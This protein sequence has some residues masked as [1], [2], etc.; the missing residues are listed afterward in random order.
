MEQKTIN[1]DV[2]KELFAFTHMTPPPRCS[3]PREIFSAHD[4][5][6]EEE[7]VSECQA[8]PAVWDAAKETL[9]YPIQTTKIWVGDSTFEE[10]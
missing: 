3:G 7:C 6:H 10:H 4:F 1:L 8:S 9:S 2:Y 5:F